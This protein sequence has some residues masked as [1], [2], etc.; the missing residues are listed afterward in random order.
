MY[1]RISPKVHS[2]LGS[3][4]QVVDA[5][6][7]DENVTVRF[8]AEDIASVIRKMSRGKTPSLSVEHLRY[9]GSHLPRVPTMRA[10]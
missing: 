1:P 2:P 4:P 5:D 6:V 9:A 8:S 3:V 7:G 10:K